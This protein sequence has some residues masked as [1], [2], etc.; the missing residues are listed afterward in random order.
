MPTTHLLA[1]AVIRREGRVLVVQAEGKQHTFLPGGHVEDDEGL[2]NCLR[3]ELR[4]ELGVEARIGSYRGAVEHR[5]QRD[6]N[7]H[8]EVNHCFFVRVPSLSPNV[9][10]RAR[11]PYLTFAWVPLH[12]LP[13]VDLQ[14]SP[15]HRLLNRDPS[16]TPWWGSTL[17]ASNEEGLHRSE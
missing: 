5:W 17:R 9:R 14:P 11:E 4:E 13:D 15:L 12:R 10:P 16:S 3:R 6:G 8:Y 7:A 1:R 2:E